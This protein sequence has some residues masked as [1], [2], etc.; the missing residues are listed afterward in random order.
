MINKGEKINIKKYN[1][2]L[3]NKCFKKSIRLETSKFD[4]IVA[5]STFSKAPKIKNRDKRHLPYLDD[6]GVSM[7]KYTF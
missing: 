4:F 7:Y 3:K 1:N 2:V 5:P 6:N